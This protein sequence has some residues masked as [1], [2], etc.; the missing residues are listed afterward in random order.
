MFLFFV[1]I[2]G[3]VAIMEAALTVNPTLLWSAEK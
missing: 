2:L 3:G 1:F